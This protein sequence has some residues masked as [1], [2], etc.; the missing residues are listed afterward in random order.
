V[1]K[2]LSIALAVL[3]AVAGVFYAF[4]R[5]SSAKE[6]RQ[7]NNE[8]AKLEGIVE[9]T[10]T[11]FSRR[12]IEIED[13]ETENEELQKKIEDRDEEIIALAETSLK[14]K[15][16]YFKVKGTQTIVDKDGNKPDLTL[17]CQDCL[18]NT[19][20]IVAFDETKDSWR[21]WGNTISNPPEAEINVAWAKG[22]KL[23]FILTRNEDKTFRLYLDSNSPDLVPAELT[24]SVDPTIFEKKWY[25]KIGIAAD[26]GVGEGVYSAI[27]IHYDIFDN[28]YVG[29]KV[30]WMYDGNQF[31]TMFGASVGWYPFR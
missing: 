12:A 13:L 30:V 20:I 3:L 9:E 28:I 16:K 5:S 6:R 1:Y 21:V 8:I 10:D 22:L 14:W 4:E 29:P 17:D 19:R 2:Y 11:A 15:E 23:S 25:E 31:R 18:L 27:Q 26:L 7:L 24:L